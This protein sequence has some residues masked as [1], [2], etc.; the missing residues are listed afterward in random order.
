MYFNLFIWSGVL[1]EAILTHFSSKRVIYFSV[2]MNSKGQL[3]LVKVSDLKKGQLWPT[4]R[5]LPE[6]W[7]LLSI[8]FIDYSLY[9]S[10]NKGPFFFTKSSTSMGLTQ[11][12]F[13]LFIKIKD[14]DHIS[15]AVACKKPGLSNKCHSHAFHSIVFAEKKRKSQKQLYIKSRQKV[16]SQEQVSVI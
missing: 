14:G 7:S 15:R 10:K 6:V 1:A 3:C 16:L 5:S 12:T 13:H 4:F 2:F 9:L 8:V 11:V